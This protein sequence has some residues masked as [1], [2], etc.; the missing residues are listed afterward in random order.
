MT[1]QLTAVLD[2]ALTHTAGF[3]SALTALAKATAT[4]PGHRPA[5][6]VL[7]GSVR[8]PPAVRERDDL[9]DDVLQ[10]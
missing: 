2:I 9:A 10:A 8:F 7:K 3:E 6:Y 4:E 1:I 5:P